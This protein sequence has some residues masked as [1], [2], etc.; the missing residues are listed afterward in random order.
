M[1]AGRSGGVHRGM[2]HG[3]LPRVGTWEKGR[4]MG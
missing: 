3:A 1:G 4:N 2:G